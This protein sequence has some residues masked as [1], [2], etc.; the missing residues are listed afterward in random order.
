MPAL[1]YS[2]KN[3]KGAAGFTVPLVTL[4][5]GVM[6]KNRSTGISEGE[7]FLGQYIGLMLTQHSEEFR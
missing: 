5:M 4:F 7:G 6:L 2:S 3:S 1:A